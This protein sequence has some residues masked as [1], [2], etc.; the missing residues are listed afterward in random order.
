MRAGRSAAE[1]TGK[2]VDF[3]IR[4]DGSLDKSVCNALADPLMHLVRNAV[5]HGIKTSG[6]VSLAATTDQ[7]ETRITVRDDGRGIDPAIVDQIFQPGYSTATEV[8]EISGRGVGLDV[9]KTT[10]DELGGTIRVSSELGKG[11]TFEIIL[12]NAD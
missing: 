9:V 2:E 1:A 7:K 12:P 8:T 5:D 11:S 3:S 10:I 4:V 6:H